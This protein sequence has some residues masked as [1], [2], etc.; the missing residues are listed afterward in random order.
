MGCAWHQAPKSS[1]TAAIEAN[2][3][4]INRS[5]S[6]VC[7]T[8]GLIERSS[9]NRS[10]QSGNQ[11]K[12]MA[13]SDH[14]HRR[15]CLSSIRSSVRSTA[16]CRL[17]ERESGPSPVQ[18]RRSSRNS[19]L[20]SMRSEV[21]SRRSYR[22]STPRTTPAASTIGAAAGC[23]LGECRLLIDAELVAKLLWL[24][25]NA[26]KPKSMGAVIFLYIFW[27][28]LLVEDKSIARSRPP[29]REWC[30]DPPASRL[31]A[32]SGSSARDCCDGII[33]TQP[34]GWVR[35]ARESGASLCVQASSAYFTS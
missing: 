6:F 4:L 17:S 20:S 30:H 16:S 15:S 32:A 31:R 25:P 18:S 35:K 1:P 5:R 13:N 22:R 8:L 23:S 28:L 27:C 24:K 19:C 33:H 10:R 9:S 14:Y 7:R 3:R 11:T 21:L 34:D 2:V 12:A 29:A 26:E